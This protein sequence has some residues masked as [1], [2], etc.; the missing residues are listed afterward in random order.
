MIVILLL[1]AFFFG[2]LVA[3]P[4]GPVGAL[5]I[6][7]T[8]RRG[9]WM[10][11]ATGAGSALADALYA[12]IVALGISTVE[13]FVVAQAKPISL[14][15]GT[16]LLLMG[17][18]AL[19]RNFNEKKSHLLKPQ[20]VQRGLVAELDEQTLAM[21]RAFERGARHGSSYGRAAKACLASFLLTVSNPL[22]IVGFAGTFAACGFWGGEAPTS[23]GDVRYLV[24]VGGIVL[25]ALSWWMSLSLLIHWLGNRLSQAWVHRI[26]FSTSLVIVVS[27][28][29]CLARGFFL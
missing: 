21:D 4:V 7:R 13:H 11:F 18:R 17:F 8:L 16:I 5:V 3:A 6:R 15:G 12:L 22:T 20:N 27:G 26:H 1:K 25:G 29:L 23:V 10:G 28:L 2:F 19:R 24:V 9:L 14:V